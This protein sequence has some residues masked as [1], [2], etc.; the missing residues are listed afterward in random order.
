MAPVIDFL[1]DRHLSPQWRGVLAAL[2]AEFETQLGGAELR[3]L[4]HR[5]GSRFA[6]AHPLPVCLSVVDL[7]RAINQRWLEADWGYVEIVEA[8]DALRIAHFCSP[9]K[10]FGANALSWTPGFLEGVYEMWLAELGGE[11]L[12]VEQTSTFDEDGVIDF[13]VGNRLGQRHR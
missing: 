4:M 9:L 1:L 7:E 13:R 3:E 8:P 5:V 10:A 12:R 2:A 11:G 6:G